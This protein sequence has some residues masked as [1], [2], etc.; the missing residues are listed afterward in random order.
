MG[1]TRSS[2][3]LGA[4][5]LDAARALVVRLLTQVAPELDVE[6]IDYSE[7]LQE[8]ADIDSMDFLRLVAETAELTGLVVPPRDYPCLA[9][10]DGF[11]RY[12]VEHDA[13]PLPA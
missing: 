11:A 2:H 8:V 12:V 9:T 13:T 7:S 10:L 5:N 3:R 1:P 6:S 4:D